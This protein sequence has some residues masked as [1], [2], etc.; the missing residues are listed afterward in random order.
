MT[1]STLKEMLTLRQPSPCCFVIFGAS[2][3]LTA[4]KLLPALHALFCMGFLPERFRIIGVA[5]RDWDGDYFR[6]LVRDSI[7]QFSRISSASPQQ[8][9]QFISSVDFA[10]ADTATP[11]GFTEL[12]AQ[13][14]SHECPQNRL[15][16]LSTPPRE[17]APIALALGANGLVHPSGSI[18]PWSRI[19][20]E[21]PFGRDLDSALKLN[22]DLQQ[23][24]SEDQIYRIDHYLGKETVQNILV[25]RF[26]NAIFEPLW[27]NHYVDHVQITVAESIGAGGRASYYDK[28]GALRDMVQNHIFQVLSL[29]AMEPPSTFDAQAVRSEKIKVLNSLRP[30]SAAEVSSSVVRGQYGVGYSLG[31]KIEAYRQEQGVA[32]NSET[33]TFVALKVLI[34]NWRWAGVPFYIR[35]GKLLAKRISEVSIHFRSVPHRLFKDVSEQ[36]KNNFL[37]IRIQ[38]EEGIS[39]LFESKVPGLRVRLQPVKMSFD[40]GGSF[41]APSPDAYERLLLDAVMGDMTLF[42]HQ[43]EAYRSWKFIGEIME[44]WDRLPPPAFPNY[45]PGSWGPDESDLLLAREGRIW[46]RL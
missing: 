43:E 1:P 29:T 11:D 17:F 12:A 27:N 45:E 36:I 14:N 7:A 25:F 5:R 40:Y 3:D 6:K 26:A 30:I 37:A 24:F 21:K 8:T 42:T 28:A 20:V 44:G 32:P 38:P 13:L 18:A 16:Y 2:G 33:E 41:G 19:I 10:S 15:F 35:T 31:K 9:E 34:D 23:V 46:R 22:S 4:R 39:L